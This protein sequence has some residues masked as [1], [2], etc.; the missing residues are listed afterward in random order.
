MGQEAT[1]VTDRR[2]LLHLELVALGTQ[3]VHFQPPPS[4]KLI[5]PCIVYRLKSTDSIAAD[6]RNYKNM[7]LYQIELI[8]PNPDNTY[9]D[10]LLNSFS[11]IKHVNTFI[12][13]NLNHYIFDLY[14]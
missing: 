6:N 3:A 12:A 11:M 5:Y 14:Y 10:S 13:D 8:D 4:V 7:K 9:V 1:E 2:K